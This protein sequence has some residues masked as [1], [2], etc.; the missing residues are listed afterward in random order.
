MTR[1]D[2]TP[3][4]GT[5]IAILAVIGAL[6][7]LSMQIV[8]P[9]L[10]VLQEAFNAPAATVQFTL[11]LALFAIAFALAEV[12]LAAFAGLVAAGGHMIYQIR[13]LDIDD[14][15]QCLRLFK[16]NSTLGWLI[17][18]GLVLGGAAAT[19]AGR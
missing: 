19:I 12:P 14:P 3:G 7:P 16:S 6:G 4:T 15:D 10:P 5:L 2:N 9:I 17:F 8:L 13:T 11:S 18:L 1:P